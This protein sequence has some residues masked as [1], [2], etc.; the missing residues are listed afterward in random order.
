MSTVGYGNGARS[1]YDPVLWLVGEIRDLLDSGTVG[2]YEF[3]WVF[4]GAEL[5][6]A[7]SQLRSYA[8]AALSLLE[9]EEALQR[10]RLTWPQESSEQTSGE[11]LSPHSWDEPGGDGTYL[12]V[13]RL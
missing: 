7:D 13:T 11:A 9:S 1:K 4:R 8:M 2:L 3:I 10:V 12:A 5:D 6:A